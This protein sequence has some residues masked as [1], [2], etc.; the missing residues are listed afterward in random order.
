M[1]AEREL[2]RAEHLFRDEVPTIHHTWLLLVLAGVRVRRGH[3]D[4][5]HTALDEAREALAQLPDSGRL[6]AMA[7]AV[8]ADLAEA[9]RRARHGELLEPPS[10]A[11]LSVLRLLATDLSVREIGERLF[12]SP[13]TIRTHR[14]LL[15]RKL[16]VHTRTDAVARAT[17]LGLLEKADHPG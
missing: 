15:Y 6:S 8:E 14:R 9:S 13:N 17:A 16:G 12:L 5:A 11:E 10:E 4:E 7:D 3:L 2:A 1:D